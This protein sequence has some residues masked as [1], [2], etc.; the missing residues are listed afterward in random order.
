MNRFLLLV[1]LI[2]LG[3]S[4]SKISCYYDESIDFRGYSSF[5]VLSFEKD[6]S[7]SAPAFDNPFNRRIIMSALNREMKNL[8]YSYREDAPDLLA[9]FELEVKE[10]VDP[11]VDSAVRY[12]PWLDSTQDTFNYTEG[13]LTV[14]ISDA[15]HHTLWEGTTSEILDRKSGH[16]DK[17]LNRRITKM[18]RTLTP[19]MH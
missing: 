4:A 13:I 2:C 19:R 16:Y 15:D 7:L 17:V 9:S 6:A 12:K 11:R 18:F 3:C 5:N 1:I 8:G 10:M 14:Q